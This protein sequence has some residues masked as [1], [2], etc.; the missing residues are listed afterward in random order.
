MFFACEFFIGMGIS[1]C[2]G[3][4][5]RRR[6]QRFGAPLER[7]PIDIRYR[8]FGKIQSSANALVPYLRE[9]AYSRKK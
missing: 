8:S 4:A 6:L 7:I 2:A 5:A 9:D 1:R 3:I